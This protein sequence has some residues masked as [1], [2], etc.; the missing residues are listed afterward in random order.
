MIF[1]TLYTPRLTLRPLSLADVEAVCAHFSDVRVTR[2]MDIDPCASLTDAEDIIRF[3][4]KDRGC[5]WG[6]FRR[7]SD[8]LIGTAGYHCWQG[9]QAEIGYDL[10]YAH[11]RQG[12]MYEAL[13]ELITFGFQQ[14]LLNDIVTE[15]DPDNTRSILLLERLGFRQI[16]STTGHLLRFVLSASEIT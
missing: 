13:D 3:H 11:W 4:L 2:F 12:F 15:V 1:P 10:G 7:P 14:M 5:R 16:E 8:N 6:L 9:L